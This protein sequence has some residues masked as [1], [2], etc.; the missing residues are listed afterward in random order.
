VCTASRSSL[1]VRC[2]LQRVELLV[3]CA[4]LNQGS[5]MMQT[6]CLEALSDD[7]PHLVKR[8]GRFILFGLAVTLCSENKTVNSNQLCR[9]ND[10]LIDSLVSN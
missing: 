4:L 1:A 5:D 10:L 3:N 2:F 9:R 6:V 7:R 8:N